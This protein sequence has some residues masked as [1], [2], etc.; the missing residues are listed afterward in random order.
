MLKD[1][2]FF[3]EVS[4]SPNLS[5]TDEDSNAWESENL[6]ALQMKL[7]ANPFHW[8]KENSSNALLFSSKSQKYYIAFSWSVAEETF[9]TT[10]LFASWFL[11]MILIE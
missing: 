4:N 2:E 1:D 10:P 9:W 11:E 3:K 6:D 7:C 8:H 5:V